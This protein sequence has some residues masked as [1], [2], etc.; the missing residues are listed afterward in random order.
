ML[1]LLVFIVIAVVI[2]RLCFDSSGFRNLESKLY[3]GDKLNGYRLADVIFYPDY[4]TIKHQYSTSDHLYRFPD[5]IG[6]IYVKRKYPELNRINHPEDFEKYK[7]DYYRFENRVLTNLYDMKIDVELLNKIIKEKKLP[8]PKF[9]HSTLLL[10]V[11][12]GDVLCSYNNSNNAYHYSKV[13][14]PVWWNNLIEYIIINKI[15]KV[16]IIAGTHFKECLKESVN[17]LE[18]IKQTLEKAKLNVIYRVGYSPDEDLAFCRYATHFITTG[19]GYG[20]FLGKIVELNGGKFVL[21]RQDT[22]RM[23]RRLFS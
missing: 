15:N 6:T 1:N 2:Y 5:T 22:V 11:R 21:N 8:Q 18:T 19:G 20:Y 10:H 12:V 9:S 16:I 4:L 23:D 17:Y 13:G 7:N 3:N 14:N